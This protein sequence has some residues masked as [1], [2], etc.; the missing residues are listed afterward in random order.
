[1]IDI[2]EKNPY[3]ILGVMPNSSKE[4]IKAQF[5]DLMKKYHPD[6]GNYE[7]KYANTVTGMIISAY[8]NVL[9]YA[10]NRIEKTSKT[11]NQA[12]ETNK[13][14]RKKQNKKNVSEEEFYDI[15]E[16]AF[17]KTVCMNRYNYMNYQVSEL[18]RK[19]KKPIYMLRYLCGVRGP[20]QNG[21]FET[22]IV[23]VTFEDRPYRIAECS[24][25]QKVFI[26]REATNIFDTNAILVVNEKG[27][28]IG[29]LAAELAEMLSPLVDKGKIEI[30]KVIVTDLHAKTKEGAV[31]LRNPWINIEIFCREGIF[32]IE[33]KYAIEQKECMLQ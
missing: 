20:I 9:N 28:S 3:K 16:K 17:K 11:S 25:G 30:E 10:S 18:L 4:D 19:Y 14:S 2:H 8:K 31:I 23:G 24:V 1:M 22:R 12:D 27:E 26:V 32:E 13:N 6:N 7:E 5:S 29:H 21:S 33:G 15:A